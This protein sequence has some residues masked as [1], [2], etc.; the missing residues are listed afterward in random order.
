MN[1]KNATLAQ[2]LNHYKSRVSILKKGFVQESYRVKKI[3]MSSLAQIQMRKITSV[4][5]ATYRDQRLTEK[6]RNSESTISPATVR[7]ELS[8]LSN[9]FDIARIEWG[10]C[11]NNPVKD[12]RKPKPAAGRDRR[13]TSREE[14]QILRYCNNHPNPELLSIVTL[15]LETAMRQGEILNIQWEDINLKARVVRLHETKNGTKRDVP[16]T[17]AARDALTRIGIKSQGR[18][19]TYSSSGI[20]S[21][22]RFMR[23]KLGIENLH[24]HDLR[25]EAISRLFETTALDAMEVAAISGHKSMSMLK[26]YTHLKAHKLVKKL[27]AGK[28]KSKQIMLT[29]LIPYPAEIIRN[30]N[31]WSGR[32]LD[33]RDS[34]AFAAADKESVISKMES[35]LL[36]LII[37]SLKDGQRTPKPDQYLETVNEKNLYMIDPL[38]N[39]QAQQNQGTHKH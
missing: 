27:E 14:R 37:F 6:K 12:V 39:T 19:F 9:V 3:S 1:K 36:R 33:F 15:A 7:L 11:G 29:N 17:L 31:G 32:L 38:N 4:D 2:A 20:K 8:L 34:M 23:E 35:E 26:R 5:I 18:V 25:H 22:W 24:F 30:Q 28:N 13:L 10:M 21:T 16:L